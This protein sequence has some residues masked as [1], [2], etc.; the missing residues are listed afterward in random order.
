MRHATRFP[1]K[2]R[3]AFPIIR[4]ALNLIRSSAHADDIVKTTDESGKPIH[5]WIKER[6]SPAI[7]S[8]LK[9]NETVNELS[10]TVVALKIIGVIS[11]IVVHH[12]N[13]RSW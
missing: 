4:V 7:K 1:G 8:C 3:L 11:R 6:S 2:T 13:G 12:D 9:L 10:T 5:R